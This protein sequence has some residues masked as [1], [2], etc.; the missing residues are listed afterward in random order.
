MRREPLIIGL[1]LLV[2][3][4]V[5]IIGTSNKTAAAYLGHLRRLGDQV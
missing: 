5:L 4:L 1:L 2:L 3:S